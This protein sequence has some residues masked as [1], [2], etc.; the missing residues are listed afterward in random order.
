MN[1]GGT[2]QPAAEKP[3]PV[4]YT[5]E[6]IRA[7]LADLAQAGFREEARSLVRKYADG[8]SLTDIDPA[9]YA[10]LAEEVR[11]HHG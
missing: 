2:E 8:G 6:E 1:E 7:M 11:K 3:A 10:D 9:S 4:T 5:K